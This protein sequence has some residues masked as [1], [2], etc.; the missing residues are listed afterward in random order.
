MKKILALMLMVLVVMSSVAAF[1][2]NEDPITG[3]VKTVGKAAQGTV[4]TAVAPVEALGKNEPAN[5]V[6]DPLKKGGETVAQA[7]E[8]T[9][10]TAT[11]QKVN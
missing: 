6:A 4:E 5:V 1:A 8:N 10:K 7:A 3:A 11:C 2:E 9:G